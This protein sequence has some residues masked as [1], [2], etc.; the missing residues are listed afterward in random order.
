MNFY[1]PYFYSIPSRS[2]GIINKL[3]L[4]SIIS[5]TNK[6]LNFI[7]QAIPIIKQMSPVMRNAKTMFNVMNEFRKSEPI[8]NKDST[9]EETNLKESTIINNSN[10]PT[11]FI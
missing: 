1:N 5:G 6:T 11:F 4:S 8:V 10:E 3:S 7:N 9:K 2:T